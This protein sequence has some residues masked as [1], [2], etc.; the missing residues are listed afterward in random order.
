MKP[1]DVELVYDLLR[2][3]EWRHGS[4]TDRLLVVERRAKWRAK[5]GAYGCDRKHERRLAR[6]ARKARKEG[7]R[8][9]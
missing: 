7:R 1:R 3:V 9:A 4:T 5:T 8:N 2:R 6:L